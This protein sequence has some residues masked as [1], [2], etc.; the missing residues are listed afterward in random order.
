M[1]IQTKEY[2]PFLKRTKEENLKEVKILGAAMASFRSLKLQGIASLRDEHK[3]FVHLQEKYYIPKE[4][5]MPEE[6]FREEQLDYN[7]VYYKRCCSMYDFYNMLSID[8]PCYLDRKAR[9]PK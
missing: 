3:D 8:N 4:F 5:C 1:L 7:V 9:R 6:L 2:Q